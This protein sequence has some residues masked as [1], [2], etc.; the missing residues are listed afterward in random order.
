MLRLLPALIVVLALSS[1]SMAAVTDGTANLTFNLS[2]PGGT[3]A[4][5]HVTAVWVTDSSNN[6]IKT[7]FKQAGTRS[8]YLYTWNAARGGQ[9]QVDGV[10]TATVNTYTNPIS[11]SWDLRDYN[12]VLKPDGA[13]R[14]HIEF[15]DKHAQGPYTFIQFNK[16]STSETIRPTD[17]AFIKGIQLDYSAT[18]VP[19]PIT[20]GLL[21]VGSMML[22]RRKKAL[23]ARQ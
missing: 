15:T 8:Q 23:G 14:I 4:P 16:D 17:L 7:I 22:L 13:Y 20:L 9:T 18:P 2:S 11:V 10:S 6:F 5:R 3:Y 1:I 21:A 19:E 12:D